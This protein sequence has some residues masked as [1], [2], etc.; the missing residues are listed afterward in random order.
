VV[1]KIHNIGLLMWESG[2]E[3]PSR[4]RQDQEKKDR[5]IAKKTEK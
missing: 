3:T 4:W 2:G 1:R 5:K